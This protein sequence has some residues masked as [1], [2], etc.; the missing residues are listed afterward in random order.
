[1][2][3]YIHTYYPRARQYGADSGRLNPHA[4]TQPAPHAPTNAA[5]LPLA[6]PA[7]PALGVLNLYTYDTLY[8]FECSPSAPC[9]PA[10][11]AL[12][13]LYICIYII[14]CIIYIH[15][16]SYIYIYIIRYVYTSAA[17]LPLAPPAPPPYIIYYVYT[18][19]ACSKAARMPR[20]V[21]GAFTYAAE[22]M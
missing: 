20:P 13:V 14:R 7:P 2:Y 15:V 8:I 5:P 12:G 6:P 1:M 11:P 18:F 22:G 21:L 9:T 4:A 10:P 17:P 19:I 3:I 16:V